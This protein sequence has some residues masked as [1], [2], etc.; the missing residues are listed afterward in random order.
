MRRNGWVV[1]LFMASLVMLMLPGCEEDDKGS[2]PIT[3]TLNGE[4]I[5]NGEWPDSGDVQ[6]SLFTSWSTNPCSWCGVAPGAPPAYYTEPLTDPDTTNEAGPDTVSFTIEG[7]ALGTYQAVAAGGRAPVTGSIN[8]TEPVIGLFGAEWGTNDSIPEAVTFSD[9]QPTVDVSLGAEFD[10][11]PFPGCFEGTISG[12]ARIDGDWPQSGLLVMLTAFPSAGWLPVLGQP[13]GYHSMPTSADTNFMFTIP[14]GSYYLSIWTLDQPPNPVWWY[15]S[16]NLDTQIRPGNAS[17]SDAHPDMTTISAADT[18]EAGI[19]VEGFT[20]APHWISGDITFNGTRPSEG[21][22]VM[23]T[24]QPVSPEQPPMQ[25]PFGYF[26]I[27]D[28]DE[29]LYALTGMPAGIYYASLWN[30]VQGP[31]SLCYGAYGYVAG[32]D[33]DP[34]AL[35]VDSSNWGY[36]N[37]DMVGEPPVPAMIVGTW[38]ATPETLDSLGLDGFTFYFYSDQTYRRFMSIANL[39]IDERGEYQLESAD[40][41]RF[42]ATWRDGETINDS[43]TWHHVL[44]DGGNELTVT[45]WT[46]PGWF[47]A[48]FTRTLLQ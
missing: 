3:G 30:N 31:G 29:T 2:P 26:L 11:L 19:I 25:Q 47:D 36:A 46:D 20:P 4:V 37:I 16:H 10:M 1:G 21:L 41:V 28:E 22:L 12:A 38:D 23:I 42:N 18:F 15:G 13:S 7:I 17:G 24:T 14:Y 33:P 44:S 6:I 27:T 35:E 43:Y 5:F 48:H 8:C 34:D 39:T 32:S 9:A 40:S 45:V